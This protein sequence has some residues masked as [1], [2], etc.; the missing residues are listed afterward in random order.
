MGDGVAVCAAGVNAHGRQQPHYRSAHHDLFGGGAMGS[1]SQR[2]EGKHTGRCLVASVHHRVCRRAM[3]GKALQ[4]GGRGCGHLAVAGKK[5]KE[6]K[7]W[8]RLAFAV[9]ATPASP[10]AG[11]EEWQRYGRHATESARNWKRTTINYKLK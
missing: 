11:G 7:I 1:E 6:D 2:C 4:F 3:G 5:K 9:S 10:G 8:R